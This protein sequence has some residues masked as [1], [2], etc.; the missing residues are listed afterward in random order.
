MVRKLVSAFLNNHA[1]W[2]TNRRIIVFESDDWGSIRMPSRQVYQ[3]C[4]QS[5]YP[6]DKIAYERY[7]SLASEEDIELLFNLLLSYKDIYGNH[8]VITANCVTSNPDFEKIRS[9]GFNTYHYELITETF[10][11]YPKHTRCFELWNE[12]KAGRIFYPQFHAREHVN[13]SLFMDSLRSGDK[14]TLFGFNHD[15]PGCIKIGTEVK[16]NSFTEPTRYSSE[17]DKNAKISIYIEGLTLFKKL[18]G[19]YSESVIPTNYIWSPDFDEAVYHKNVRYFQGLRKM[20]EP[21]SNGKTRSYNCHL[22]MKNKF[23]Q[24]Y[25]VRNVLFEPSLF[26]LNIKDPVDNALNSIALAFLFKKPAIIC[27]HRINYVGFI[28]EEN[29]DRTLSQLKILLSSVL[30]K[31]PDVEFMTTVQLGEIINN[32]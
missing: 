16:G 17:E 14:D 19:Y 8:P 3:K 27:S 7:D 30:K 31:W 11:K 24:T 6:V 9:D 26:R 20:Y 25:L 13:V 28:D 21:Q 4:L 23:G 12:G 22:G 5:G 10:K 29:R 18:F 1:G 32:E 2:R 15:M